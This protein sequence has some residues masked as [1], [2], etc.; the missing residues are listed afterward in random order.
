MCTKYSNIN[1]YVTVSSILLDGTSECGLCNL[2]TSHLRIEVHFRAS[3][4]CTRDQCPFIS[5][6]KQ[7]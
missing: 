2:F 3:Q 1:R 4:R 5:K 7:K 6:C